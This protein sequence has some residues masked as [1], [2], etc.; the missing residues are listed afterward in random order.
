MA[1]S[2]GCCLV[3]VVP[4]LAVA[5]TT[6]EPLAVVPT[7][8][9]C[10]ASANEIA[11]GPAMVT[12]G[13]VATAC[14]LAPPSV[15]PAIEIAP[16]EPHAGQTPRKKAMFASTAANGPGHGPGPSAMP[17]SNGYASGVFLFS[18]TAC[19]CCP[20]SLVRYTT[21]GR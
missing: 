11:M 20:A 18:R 4:P 16:C 14:Q 3:Q 15:V 21:N 17:L 5:S 7:T 19:Q 9:P 8:Q 1:S 10:V 12:S 2:Q 13:T 6:G